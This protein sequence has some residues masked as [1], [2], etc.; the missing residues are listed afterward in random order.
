MARGMKTSWGPWRTHKHTFTHS[1][2]ACVGTG[3]SSSAAGLGAELML[4]EKISIPCG[5]ELAFS[6]D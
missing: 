5:A 2:E 3:V 6:P 4:A 1:Q